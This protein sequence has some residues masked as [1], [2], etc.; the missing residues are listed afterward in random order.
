M[1]LHTLGAKGYPPSTWDPGGVPTLGPCQWPGLPAGTLWEPHLSTGLLA[2]NSD[3]ASDLAYPRIDW[4]GVAQ[5]WQILT[6]R[7]DMC[8]LVQGTVLM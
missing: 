3:P 7:R 1:P 8:K 2:E 4:D 6:V 5:Y